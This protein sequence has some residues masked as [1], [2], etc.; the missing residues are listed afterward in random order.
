MAARGTASRSACTFSEKAWAEAPITKT[1]RMITHVVLFRV[2]PDL[3]TEERAALLDAFE[4]AVR[5]IPTVRGARAGARVSLGAGYERHGPDAFDYLV[6][7]DFDDLS[8]LRDYLQHPAH[9][10][11]G[12]RF[13]LACAETLV[14]DFSST[15]NISSI[16]T[17]FE[18]Q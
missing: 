12:E 8:G 17:L 18:P 10:D 1:S 9:V 6:E 16:R 13:N 7:I 14:Y 4:R 2:R 5:Q 15:Q 11:L 3:A